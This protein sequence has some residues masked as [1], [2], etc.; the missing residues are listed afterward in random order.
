MNIQLVLGVIVMITIGTATV[1]TFPSQLSYGSH[2]PVIIERKAPAVISGENV[3]ITW[4]TNNTENKND[5]VMF[6]SS[7]DG[8]KTFGDKINL[9]N[10]KEDDSV[11]VDIAA[12]G[13]KVLVSWW[14]RNQTGIIPVMKISTDGGKTFGPMLKLAT[15]GTIGG[16]L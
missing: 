1:T 13:S 9:S 16:G 2:V 14:E 6:R 7:A 10:T 8:G 4:W 3:Y 15:N 12:E 5:E 11:N